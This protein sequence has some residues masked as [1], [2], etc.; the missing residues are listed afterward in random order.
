MKSNG[1]YAAMNDAALTRPELLAG[2]K[3]R[4]INMN[5]LGQALT[6][7]DDPPVQAMSTQVG[8]KPAGAPMATFACAFGVGTERN[9]HTM[10]AWQ[11]L[12][13][14]AG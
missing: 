8:R 3:V 13:V 12:H 5:Q 14:P 2:R 7:L 1:G 11:T 6:E 9:Q 10:V 4:S